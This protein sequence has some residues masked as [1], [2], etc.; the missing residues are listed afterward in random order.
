MKGFASFP[1]SNGESLRLILLAVVED[2]ENELQRLVAKE[3]LLQTKARSTNS[4]PGPELTL[5][6]VVKRSDPPQ[7]E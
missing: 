7:D 5:A 6:L 4:G 3:L 2:L 1:L